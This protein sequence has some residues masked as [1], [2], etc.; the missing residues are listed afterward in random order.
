MFGLSLGRLGVLGAVALCLTLTGCASQNELLR[1]SYAGYTQTALDKY[2]HAPDPNYRYDLVKTDDNDGYTTYIIRMVSQKWLTEAE[3]DR[4][5]W[6]HWL[7]IVRPDK[8]DTHKGLLIIGGGNND[9][10]MPDGA[11]RLTT[12]LAIETGS[13]VSQLYMV[14]NQPLKFNGESILR[15]EDALIAYTWDKY[16]RTQDDRWP[17][18]LPMTKSAVR[19]MDTITDFTASDEGGGVAVEEFIVTGGSKRGWATWTTAAVDNRVVAIM[20]VV[21]DMLNITPSFKHHYEVYGRY[22]RAIA[23]YQRSN[24]MVRQS[25]PEFR[26]LMEIVEPY[27]YR[28]R[29]A[30][31]KYIV[32]S[33]GDQF[34]IPDSWQFYWNDL[35]G[36][37]YLRY[38]PNTDHG[39]S[40]SDYAAS[41]L[42]WYHAIVHNVPRPRFAWRVEEDGTIRVH[43]LDKPTE[44]RLWS[45]TNPDARNFQK[46]TIGEAWTSVTLE[47]E[48]R[49]VYV[50]RVSPPETGWTAFFV[51][52]T[53]PS[54]TSAPFKFTTGTKVVPDVKPFTYRPPSEAEIQEQLATN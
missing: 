50:G 9:G 8:V 21:I 22:A 20:P 37:K 11:N 36:E 6:W 38:I 28:E 18:R 25:T 49:G 32:N 2:V 5:I 41:A 46:R 3:V 13:I 33:A 29:L 31:P 1:S 47:E 16:M 43:T 42:A 45:A 27:E 24:I 14:P 39:L 53:F 17:A 54:G 40:G 23:D 48:E 19:A 35:D 7:V 12:G 34:F 4:P 52:L 44:V 26:S 10:E 15:Y 30:L 51:E